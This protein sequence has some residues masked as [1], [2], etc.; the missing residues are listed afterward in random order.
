MNKKRGLAWQDN[1][2]NTYNKGKYRNGEYAKHLR[3]FLKTT[4]NRKWRRAGQI[5]IRSELSNE[6]LGNRKRIG[7][8]DKRTIKVKIKQSWG[9][10]YKRTSIRKFRTIRDVMNSLKRNNVIEGRILNV[11]H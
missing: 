8:K 3:Q 10:D 4:G 6:Y 5:E 1:M 11:G 9:K 7:R 2:R